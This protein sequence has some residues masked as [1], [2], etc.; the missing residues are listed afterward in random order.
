MRL[1]KPLTTFIKYDGKKYPVDLSFNKVL[2]VL[3]ILTRKDILKA[4]KLGMITRRLF[5]NASLSA[6]EQTELWSIVRDEHINVNSKQMIK[7]DRN[8]D[9]MPVVEEEKN[10]VMDLEIDAKYIYA[11]FRQIGINLFQEQGRMQW[12]EFQSLLE[13]LPDDT[14]IQK[15]IQIRL[16]TPKKGES[17]EY[18]QAMKK[19]QDKYRLPEVGEDDE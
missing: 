18:K 1:N 11:S 4:H 10:R 8:G 15:I 19:A 2:D 12:V 7:Y 6:I 9:P 14:I 16:W 13:S 5:G 17:A 3:E